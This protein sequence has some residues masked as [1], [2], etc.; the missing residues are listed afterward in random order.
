MGSISNY[1]TDI[2]GGTGGS[3]GGIPG[4]G[5][6]VNN[7][8]TYSTFGNVAGGPFA[9]IEGAGNA[10]DTGNA[11][12]PNIVGTS[13]PEPI[14]RSSASASVSRIGNRASIAEISTSANNDVYQTVVNDATG[15]GILYWAGVWGNHETSITSASTGTRSLSQQVSMR[16]TIDGGTPIE[17]EAPVGTRTS[18]GNVSEDLVVDSSIFLGFPILSE[19][20]SNDTDRSNQGSSP[21]GYSLMETSVPVNLD[22]Q[23][24][25]VGGVAS[26]RWTNPGTGSTIRTEVDPIGYPAGVLTR[27]GIPGLVYETSILVEAKY[28]AIRTG[29]WNGRAGRFDAAA[30][31]VQF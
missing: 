11:F 28:N 10:E 23:E 31:T 20:F 4:T 15:G 18:P 12:N 16:I 3:G 19:T 26:M 8:I 25:E 9:V 21:S 6:T 29:S 30:C 13:A 14:F 7:D 24:G 17:F 1:T 27:L 5:T 2:T 22:F